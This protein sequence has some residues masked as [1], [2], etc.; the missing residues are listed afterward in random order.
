MAWR[1]VKMIKIN[2]LPEEYRKKKTVPIA[3]KLKKFKGFALPLAGLAVGIVIVITLLIFVYPSWQ[4]RTLSK[5]ENKWTA[6][7]DDYQEA[8]ELEKQKK[9]ISEDLKWTEKVVAARLLWAAALNYISDALPQEIQL[10]QMATRKE[11]KK[12]VLII[13]GLVPATPGER[14]I[15]GFVKNLQDNPDLRQDF[16]EILPPSTQTEE[17]GI[18]TFTLKCYLDDKYSLAEKE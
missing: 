17:R 13:S 15:E 18:K 9:E 16:S 3:E 8:Q 6:L 1:I 4:E 7:A 12:K 5:L 10:T 11:Q 2:L 14:A